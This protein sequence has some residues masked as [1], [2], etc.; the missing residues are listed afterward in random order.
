MQDDLCLR[1]N[2][3][4]WDRAIRGIIAGALIIWPALAHWAPW[5]TALVAAFGGG[6]AVEALI[7]Y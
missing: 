6:L 2:T 1:K 4:N 5:P 7:G 3:G